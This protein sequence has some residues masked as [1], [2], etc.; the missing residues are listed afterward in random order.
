MHTVLI[1]VWFRMD[2]LAL[3][4]I[5]YGDILRVEARSD[6]D[7]HALHVGDYSMH[8]EEQRGCLLF[9]RSSERAIRTGRT[10]KNVLQ[11]FGES[12]L[13][14]SRRTISGSCSPARENSRRMGGSVAE[15]SIDWRF[16]GS[17]PVMSFNWGAKPSSKS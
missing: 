2:Y 1:P 10:R 17:R 15:T 6:E 14:M 13:S 16:T 3:G 11:R 12:L 8:Q 5:G 9:L 4:S 7:E